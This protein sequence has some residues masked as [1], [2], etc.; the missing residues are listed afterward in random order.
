MRQCY[1]R[2]MNIEPVR[3]NSLTDSVRHQIVDYIKN[4][5]KNGIRKLPSENDLSKA[6]GISRVTLRRALGQLESEGMIMRKHGQGTFVNEEALKVKVN[7]SEMIDFSDIIRRAGQK[8]SHEINLLC[9]KSAD[10]DMA[11]LLDVEQG[12]PLVEVEYALYA[13]KV[14]AIIARGY[15]PKRILGDIPSDEVWNAHSCFEI[16]AQYGRTLVECDR[17]KLQAVS[18]QEMEEY[19]GHETKIMNQTVLQL[20]SVGFDQNVVP[21]IYGE[22][23]FDTNIIQFD[24]YRIKK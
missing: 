14:Q 20:S 4:N 10:A 21:V 19:L 16:L 12:E 13:G 6:L 2:Y 11:K 9:E 18:R 17:V 23:F 8:P 24:L 22:A 3:K 15:F 5:E 7:L 1:N